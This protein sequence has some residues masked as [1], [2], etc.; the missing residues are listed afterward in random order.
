MHESASPDE[1]E[2]DVASADHKGGRYQGEQTVA[3]DERDRETRD[4]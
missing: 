4:D 3:G 2:D 1:S